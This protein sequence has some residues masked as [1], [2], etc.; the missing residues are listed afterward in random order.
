MFQGNSALPLMPYHLEEFAKQFNGGSSNTSDGN[1]IVKVLHIDN[2]LVF[3]KSDGT[4]IVVDL[5]GPGTDV[6]TVDYIL[7]QGAWV[8]TG[9]SSNHSNRVCTKNLVKGK[10]YVKVKSG[11]VIRAVYSYPS[12]DGGTGSMDADTSTSRTEYTSNNDSLYYGVTFAKTDANADI[13][14]NEDIVAEWY[15]I[16]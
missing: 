12:V 16:E 3:K 15:F 14:P 2:T 1:S 8:N 6:D 4:R 9:Y 5:S 7:T 10:F 13:S 11:Y